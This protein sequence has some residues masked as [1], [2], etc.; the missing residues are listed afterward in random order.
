MSRAA[1]GSHTER[2]DE[3]KNQPTTETSHSHPTR[4]PPQLRWIGAAA[5]TQS[6]DPCPTGSWLSPG[7]E[8]L[9]ACPSAVCIPREER[10]AGRHGLCM[11][12]PW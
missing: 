9:A 4:T 10:G 2:A 3:R 11:D 6:G 8:P 5:S 7:A 12:L 1:G